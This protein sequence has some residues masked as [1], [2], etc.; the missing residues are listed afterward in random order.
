MSKTKI[1]QLK[2]NITLLPLWPIVA[3][4]SRNIMSATC[5]LNLMVATFEKWN[6]TCKFNFNDI[7]YLIQYIDDFIILNWNQCKNYKWNI[8]PL[9]F[10]N[11]RSSNFNSLAAHLNSDEPDFKCSTLTCGL[12]LPHWIVTKLYACGRLFLT[13]PQLIYP[14]PNPWGLWMPPYLAKG[15]VQ[16]WL[17]KNF[18]VGRL[19]GIIWEGL[20][21]SRCS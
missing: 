19:P 6:E 14:H 9:F 11:T 12:C 5:N 4:S 16:M 2:F 8:L 3:L 13:K 10:F 17:V 7:F 15:N 20:M 1:K 18:E 21:Q